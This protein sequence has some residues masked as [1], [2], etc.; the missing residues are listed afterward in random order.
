MRVYSP[1]NWYDV[2]SYC[3]NQWISDYTYDAMYDYM[4]SHSQ[5]HPAKPLGTRLQGDWLSVFGEIIPGSDTATLYHLRHLDSVALVPDLDPGDF[6]IRLLDATDAVLADYPFSPGPVYNVDPPRLSIE[7]VVS[8]TPGTAEVQIVRISDTLVLTSETLSVNPPTISDVALQG[9]P[10]PVTGTVTLGWTASDPD[11][12]PLT[13]DILYSTDIAVPFQPVQ[14][15]V[16]GSSAQ[17]DTLMLGGSGGA[18]LR[19]VAS[20]GVHSAQADSDPFTMESKPPQ[21][22]ILTPVDGTQIHWGQLLNFS[23]EALDPQDGSVA[24][25]NLVW[26]NQH[27]QLGTGA[28]LSV[29]DL[30]VGT[31]H[32]TLG[33]TNSDGLYAETQ[34]TVIVDDDLDWPG[35]TLSAAP[36][37]IAWHVGVEA[38]GMQTADLSIS[39]VGTGDVVWVASEDADW[40]TLSADSGTTPFTLTLTADPLQFGPGTGVTTT[41][42][43]VSPQTTGHPTQTVA[44]PVSLFVGD[45]WRV[46]PWIPSHLIYLPLI[47]K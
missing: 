33:A 10:D 22:H 11:G 17:I 7:Q 44:I 16:G 41:L 6:S 37:Q 15:G 1:F 26:S 30:P 27:G 35:P 47:F 14:V 38:M 42:W 24:A 31:N 29:D 32:I 8:Y 20:D 43:I 34:I 5:E 3:D 40:L 12:D 13:F 19:V 46:P 28:L 23:G 25:A 21:P 18:V 45:V 4:M 36:D 9:A 2:M 39:N